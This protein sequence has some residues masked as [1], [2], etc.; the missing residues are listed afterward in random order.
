MRQ[1]FFFCSPKWGAGPLAPAATAPNLP[2]DK[3]VSS[4]ETKICIYFLT[5]DLS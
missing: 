5:L 4:I 3:I 1:T 2:N